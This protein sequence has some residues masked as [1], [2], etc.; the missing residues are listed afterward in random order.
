MLD[1]GYWILDLV[2][3]ANRPNGLNGLT[4]KPRNTGLHIVYLKGSVRLDW[5]KRTN[6]AMAHRRQLKT[7]IKV[8]GQCLSLIEELTTSGIPASL[9]LRRQGVRIH[10]R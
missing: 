10:K 5:T 2:H 9:A 7:I 3:P 4:G 6:P 8:R 1:A